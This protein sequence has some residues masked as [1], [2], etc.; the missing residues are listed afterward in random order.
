MKHNQY[1]CPVCGYET[2]IKTHM[3]DHLYNRK[4]PC[5]VTVNNMELTDDIKE[6]VL[7][8]RVYNPSIHD[9]ITAV[10]VPTAATITN[11]TKT[12][13]HQYNIV[14]NF[15]GGI[16]SIDKIQ[17]YLDHTNTKMVGIDERVVSSFASKVRR[18]E[19]NPA[20]YIMKEDDFLESIDGASTNTH[21]KNMNIIFNKKDKKI[22][23][24]TTKWK[25]YMPHKAIKIILSSIQ[26]NYF[27]AYE[28]Y[29]IRKLHDHDTHGRLAA[30]VPLEELLV[31]YYTFIA[32]FDLSPFIKDRTNTDILNA[33]FDDFDGAKPSDYTTN[34]D[35]DDD[36][37][38]DDDAT[39]QDLTISD[40]YCS[41]FEKARQNVTKT[42]RNRI[43][44]AVLTIIKNNCEASLG[45]LNQK[46]LDL[47][48][49]DDIFKEQIMKRGD[50]CM[51]TLSTPISN[52]AAIQ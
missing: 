31:E 3:K 23:I 27:D 15:I 10:A 34:E 43:E 13:I 24:F 42:D 17:Y 25:T 50:V 6:L 41:K 37:V 12:I 21:V 20:S 29:L 38:D 19:Q 47:F 45:H 40:K 51:T 32:Y 30:R 8:N 52:S 28:C 36:D 22:S 46:V 11:N 1:Q 44:K 4:A 2:G 35:G 5:P 26:E 9:P 39:D 7:K 33:S 14:N 49:M 16:P 18:L 48:K